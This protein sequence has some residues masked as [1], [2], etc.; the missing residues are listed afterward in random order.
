MQC[1]FLSYFQEKFPRTVGDVEIVCALTFSGTNPSDEL[2]TWQNYVATV[3]KCFGRVVTVVNISLKPTLH[4]GSYWEIFYEKL[5]SVVPTKKSAAI[6]SGIM[7]N[8]KQLS[9]LVQEEFSSNL[10]LNTHALK[11]VLVKWIPS[12]LNISGEDSDDPSIVTNIP[13]VP[14]THNGENETHVHEIVSHVTY[15]VVE[16]EDKFWMYI[17]G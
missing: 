16:K 10:L 8:T 12:N 7:E 5:L 13:M 3:E 15:A 11:N 2:Q 4:D 6:L 1:V 17:S 14:E 9:D